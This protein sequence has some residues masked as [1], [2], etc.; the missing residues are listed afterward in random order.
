MVGPRD[1]TKITLAKLNRVSLNKCYNPDC[2]EL[3]ISKDGSTILGNIVHICAAS[4]N[5][6]R[7][8][9]SMSTEERRD[10]NNLILLCTD[11]HKII[12]NPLNENKYPISLLK[13]WKKM[14][15]AEANLE[16]VVSNPSVLVGAIKAIANL[17][18]DTSS[19]EQSVIS[20]YNIETKIKYNDLKEYKFLIQEYSV[21]A[22]KI[23]TIYNEL[24]KNSFNSKVKLLS[25]IRNTYLRVKGKYTQG[26]N[27]IL[28][29]R[30]NADKIYREIEKYIEAQVLQQV[31]QDDIFFAIPIIM[32]D[33]FI[34]CK[35][36][37]KP[38]LKYDFK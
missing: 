18:I 2:Q 7:F 28:L 38:P 15:E 10:Y 5:G 26:K 21:L 6:P 37:E 3:L 12:D 24:D 11:C 9:S 32:A 19:Y 36:L 16:K 1:Y 25:I 31:S 23:E 30:K 13:K 27:D 35:I 29:V 34:R 8:D 4:L 22:G 14:R 20:A 33:A 17:Q